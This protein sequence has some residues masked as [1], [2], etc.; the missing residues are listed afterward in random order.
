MP[1]QYV[2]DSS[3]RLVTTI[4]S[5]VLTFSDVAAC[6]EAMRADPEFQSDFRHLNDVTQVTKFSLRYDDLHLIRKSLD[7][8][9][10]QCRRAFVAP[11]SGVAF[12]L[13]R[14][15][16][17]M[18]GNPNCEVFHSLDE[19]QRWLGIEAASAVRDGSG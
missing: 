4:C 18:L 5:G 7:P 1:L 16:Q 13:A 3:N 15:Y 17:L 9:S 10:D 6:T 19:A 12:G 11:G 14:M 2:I 8:F